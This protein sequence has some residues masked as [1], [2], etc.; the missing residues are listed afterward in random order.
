MLS[1]RQTKG[2]HGQLGAEGLDKAPHTLSSSPWQ[3][4]TAPRSKW[5]CPEGH[6]GLFRC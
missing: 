3:G 4:H 5:Q 2:G 1:H 6:W